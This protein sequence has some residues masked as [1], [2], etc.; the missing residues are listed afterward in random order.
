MRHLQTALKALSVGS[1]SLYTPNEGLDTSTWMLI[2]GV[3]RCAALHPAVRPPISHGLVA[4]HVPACRVGDL[5]SPPGQPPTGG[6]ALQTA[7]YRWERKYPRA[8]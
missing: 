5:R 3:I 2:S 6:A 7:C 4:C 8:N 1:G